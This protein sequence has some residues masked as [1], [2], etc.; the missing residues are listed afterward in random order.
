MDAYLLV[1]LMA[2]GALARRASAR[3]GAPVIAGMAAGLVIAVL[4]MVTFAVLDNAFLSIVSHQQGKIDGFRGSGMTSM[5]AYI[6][7]GLEAT[8]PGV[9]IVLT[10]AGS[11][12]APLG[13]ALANEAAIAWPRLR[14]LPRR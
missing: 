8:A 12:F 13:A 2:V 11:V 5:R 4:G 9:A 6:N 1:A 14:H 10:I 3:P 7:G